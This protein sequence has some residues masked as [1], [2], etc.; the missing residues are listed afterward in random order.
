MEMKKMI[1]SWRLLKLGMGT[2][3]LIILFH[4]GVCSK[5]S[6]AKGNKK[7]KTEKPTKYIGRMFEVEILK[8]VQWCWK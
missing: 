2:W 1:E 6:R 7:Q 8:V 3:E 5:F 4:L